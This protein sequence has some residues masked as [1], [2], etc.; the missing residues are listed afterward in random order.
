M[1]SVDGGT[2][3]TGES[4][5]QDRTGG[6]QKKQVIQAKGEKNKKISQRKARNPISVITH[7]KS[8]S[9]GKLR[10]TLWYVVL[11]LQVKG[12]KETT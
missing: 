6:G 5:R 2:N 10:A 4:M 7:E 1:R 11:D 12:A 9:K 8:A 3:T